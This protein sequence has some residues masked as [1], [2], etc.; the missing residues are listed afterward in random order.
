MENILT[1]KGNPLVRSGNQIYYGS[2]EN[3]YII[4]IKIL[5]TKNAENLEYATKLNIELQLNDPEIS[6]MDKIKKTA[7]RTNLY[8]ALDIAEIWLRKALTNK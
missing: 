6:D 1:Y 4:V 5:E 3:K 2:L 7:Q 8:E